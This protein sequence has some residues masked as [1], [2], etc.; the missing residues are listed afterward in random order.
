M[1]RS[2]ISLCLLHTHDSGR[3]VFPFL[4]KTLTLIFLLF[5]VSFY[6]HAQ[7]DEIGPY[8]LRLNLDGNLLQIPYYANYNLDSVHPGFRKAVVVIHGMNRNA[9]DY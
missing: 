3:N 1:K 8:R 9:G 5:N 6:A 7:V 4:F 2:P